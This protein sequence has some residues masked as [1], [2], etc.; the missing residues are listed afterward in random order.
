M[1]CRNLISRTAICLYLVLALV[2][3]GGCS[4]AG[5]ENDVNPEETYKIIVIDSCEYIY[6][7]RRPWGGEMA[8]T[9]KGN[10]KYCKKRAL[11]N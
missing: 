11:A 5:S 3:A 6:L 8:L 2:F 10:C 7:T 9:H 1:K 4:P